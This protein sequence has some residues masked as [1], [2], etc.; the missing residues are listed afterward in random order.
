[1]PAPPFSRNPGRAS[2]LRSS[3]ANLRTRGGRLKPLSAARPPRF[4]G[5]LFPG[6]HASKP[7]RTR[8]G[9]SAADKPKQAR[10]PGFLVYL[11]NAR[12]LRIHAQ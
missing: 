12:P 5:T 4:D 11:G 6:K 10:N 2:F 9:V 1:M 3:Q 8:H 7:S